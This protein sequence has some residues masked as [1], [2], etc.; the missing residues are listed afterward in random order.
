MGLDCN[1]LAMLTGSRVVLTS[2]TTIKHEY[3]CFNWIPIML[4]LWMLVQVLSHLD[5]IVHILALTLQY[6]RNY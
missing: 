4:T 3:V 1:S 5:Y 2:G 6:S